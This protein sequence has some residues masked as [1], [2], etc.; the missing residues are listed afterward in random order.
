MRVFVAGASGAIGRPLVRQLLAA[1][2]DV[3][4][5]TRRAER[6]EKIRAAGA[7]AAVVDVFDAEALNAAVGEARPEVIVHELTSLP[8]VF[9]PRKE[10]YDATNRVRREGTR[11]LIAAARAAGTRR[12]VVQSIGF[13]YD[14]SGD[15]VKDEEAPLMSN[16]SGSFASA[17]AVLTEMERQALSAEGIEGLVLRY[18]FFYGPATWYAP[19]RDQAEQVRRRRLPIVGSG[20][21]TF[22]FIHVD[23]AA[24]ATVAACQRGAPGIYNIVDDDP[25]PMREWLPVYADALGAKRPRHVPAWIVRLL[26]GP[27]VAGFATEMRGASNAK[28]RRELGWEPLHSSWRTGFAESMRTPPAGGQPAAQR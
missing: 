7:Q 27:A 11:N 1:G 16:P 2:H 6:A 17:F 9:D 5:M 21:G 19:G 8:D 13:A 26:A 4:G 12:L 23:D 15:W 18:G 28:A 24:A 22:S 10:I 3:T 14:P 25:A 20:Q